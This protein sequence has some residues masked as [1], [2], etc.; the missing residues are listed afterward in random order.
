LPGL[1][2]GTSYEWQV[3]GVCAAN[4]AIT[5]SAWSASSFF[6]TNAP[7]TIAPNPA[8]DKITVTYE[9]T[10]EQKIN[11]MIRDFLGNFYSAETMLTG[12]GS[13]HYEM[14]VSSLKNG[15]YYLELTGTEGHQTMKFYVQH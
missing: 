11:L 7:L 4:G 13:N 1:S 8:A 15:I 10:V 12:T 3:Q 2:S 14:N 6:T 9:S 5:L